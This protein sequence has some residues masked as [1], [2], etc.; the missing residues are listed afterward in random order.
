MKGWDFQDVDQLYD[1]IVDKKEANE[2]INSLKICDPAVG[3]G[4]FLVSA[5]NEMIA[6][7]SELKI[8]LDR[9]GKTLRDYHIEVV[10][11]ELIVTDDD[12]KLFEYNP[13]NR[14]SQRIQEALFYEKQTIIEN[15]LFGVDVNTNSVK[16]CRLRLWIELLKN[17]YYKPASNYSELETLPN[18]DI[19][20]KCGNSLISRFPLDADLREALR[21][22]E[23]NISSY[24]SAVQTYRNAQSK[25]HK[26]NMERL[27]SDIKGN[28]RTEISNNDP[29]VKRL[30][31][32][33]RE[34]YNLLNQMQLFEETKAEQKARKQKQDKLEKDT[35]QLSNDIE[36]IKSNKIYENAF[37]WRFEFPEV[38][39]NDGDFSGFDVIIGNPPYL[40]FKSYSVAER[41]IF[42]I[43]F[44]EIFDGKA[45]IYYFFFTQGLKILKQNGVLSYISSRYWIEAEFAEKLRKN[46]SNDYLI[47]EIIDFKNATIF[48]GIGIKTAIVILYKTN[49][50]QGIKFNYKYIDSKKIES[51]KIDNFIS[52]SVFIDN[53]KKKSKWVLREGVELEVYEKIENGTVPLEAIA[54]CKQGI[55]TGLD[56]A[57]ITT[58]NDFKDIP[59]EYVKTWIKVGDVFRY[60]INPVENRQLIYTNEITNLSEYP[61]LEKRLT[62]Y[63]LKLSG[64]REA[65]SGKIRW[66]DLQWSRDA[67]LFDSQKLVCRF[68]ASHNTFALDGNK[69]YSSADT[70][71]VVLKK[72]F[73]EDY[74]LKFVLA[75]VNSKL[76]DF[77]F[78][79]YGKLMDYRFEYYPGPVGQIRIKKAD[80][81]QDFVEIVDQILAIKRDSP[82]ADT[83]TLEQEIDQMVY[84]LYELTE[85][86]IKIIEENMV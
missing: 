28:L 79:S 10:N 8:L 19:N 17:A 68:K 53:I 38:L 12:E 1:K 37:E 86:E 72:Q 31:K 30:R 4:H 26:R 40:N 64:R 14:E 56:K 59:E 39:N 25:E 48:E 43:E 71:I 36:E 32:L 74:D 27:I 65:K 69:F 58:S 23:W 9:E 63:Q 5:L 80:N 18:I 24:R 61:G 49:P 7:K 66:F 44:S 16:I 84:Q 50:K 20:I 42:K 21:K 41:E 54:D 70:T 85:K 75:L 60:S 29:K 34:L 57:F 11:D 78:K 55:V 47:H 15:C 33:D 62:S 82:N 6:I 76:L 45:D 2:I 83:T 46:L 81:Q 77:Y 52:V 3:S 67:A 51:V 13:R 35:K 22:S 73:K